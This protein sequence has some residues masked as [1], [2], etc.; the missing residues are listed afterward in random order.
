MEAACGAAGFP[1]GKND[2]Y[3]YARRHGGADDLT[4]LLSV[5]VKLAVLAAV[6]GV[7]LSHLNT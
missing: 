5:G 1:L 3:E 2:Y 4:T 7:A 6:G